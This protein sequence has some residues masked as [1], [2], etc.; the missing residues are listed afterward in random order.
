MIVVNLD[1]LADISQRL[2]CTIFLPRDL[3]MKKIEGS[4]S[5]EPELTADGLFDLVARAAIIL[6]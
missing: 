1:G 2:R 6:R 4:G 5:F 3:S